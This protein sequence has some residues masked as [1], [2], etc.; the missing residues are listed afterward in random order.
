MPSPRPARPIVVYRHPLSGHCHR[1]ELFLHMLELPVQLRDIDLRGGEHKRREYLAL[2]T[3]GQVPVIDDDGTIVSDSNAILCYLALRYA[4]ESWLPRDPIGAARVQ[5][6]LSAAAG[7]LAFG[8]ARSRVVELFRLQQDT[9]DAVE[10]AH[11]LCAVIEQ[12]LS[13]V[14]GTAFIAG[15]APTIADLALYG[16]SAHAPEGNVALD[17]YPRL[18]EW[19]ARIEALPRFLPMT[20]SR[21]GLAA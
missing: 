12:T 20:A 19:L 8:A 14:D 13:A 7:P 15:A 16:Y 4:D 6:W 3:F 17:A 18:R 11:M 1:V 5:R 21:I 9:R 2:N 10:R